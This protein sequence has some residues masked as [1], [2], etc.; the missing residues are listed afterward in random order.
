VR[1]L[2]LAGLLVLATACATKQAEPTRISLPCNS[3]ATVTLT[4]VP[5]SMDKVL[6]F[7]GCGCI[8][9]L[10]EDGSVGPCRH[11]NA[12]PGEIAVDSGGDVWIADTFRN[13]TIVL[14]PS[15]ETLILRASNPK[16]APFSVASSTQ[17]RG[18]WL[19]ET[20]STAVRYIDP[21]TGVNAHFDLGVQPVHLA[22][23]GQSALV[24]LRNGVVKRINLRGRV[25]TIYSAAGEKLHGVVASITHGAWI[26]ASNAAYHVSDNSRVSRIACQ[27]CDLAL[28]TS[29]DDSSLWATD[30][31][32]PL[33]FRVRR[34]G[35]VTKIAVGDRLHI[36]GYIVAT[37]DGSV[38][39]AVRYNLIEILHDNASPA[40]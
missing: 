13:G 29:S 7:D 36:P 26:L 33:V 28:G 2:G 37:K 20:L 32:H 39:T 27:G 8:R 23:Q 9:T 12:G 17:L 31:L 40:K 10:G 6:S 19:I 22:V 30:L 3:M 24:I 34:D 15:N 5:T 1:L 11:V 16:S 35:G 25:D 38:W 18:A 4:R 21:A 14:K